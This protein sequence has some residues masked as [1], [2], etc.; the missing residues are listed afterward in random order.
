M[1]EI[2]Y[3]NVREGGGSWMKNNEQNVDTHSPFS[4]TSIWLLSPLTAHCLQGVDGHQ[5]L[6]SYLYS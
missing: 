4:E 3:T 5:E 1:S 2:C 6:L